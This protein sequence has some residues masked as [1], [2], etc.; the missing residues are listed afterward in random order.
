LPLEFPGIHHMGDE[1]V[2]AAVRVL[3][4]RSLFR[5]YGVDLQREVD[6]FEEEFARFT[7][8]RYAL[9]VGSGTGALAVALSALG[10]GPGQEIIVPKKKVLRFRVAKAAKDAILGAK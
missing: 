4:A 8:A 2:E 6:S 1:E 3:R 10:A 7:G 5:Y 9:A